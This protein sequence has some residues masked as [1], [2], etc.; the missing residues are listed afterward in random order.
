MLKLRS[1]AQFHT[2]DRR[3]TGDMTVGNKSENSFVCSCTDKHTEAEDDR[4]SESKN[5]LWFN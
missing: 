3:R 2:V 5:T 1:R 4:I